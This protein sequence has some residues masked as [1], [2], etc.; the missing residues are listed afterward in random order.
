[1]VLRSVNNDLIGTPWLEDSDEI[2]SILIDEKSIRDV[3]CKDEID[4]IDHDDDFLYCPTNDQLPQVFSDIFGYK[5]VEATKEGE[6]KFKVKMPKGIIKYEYELIKFDIPVYK[7]QRKV[8]IRS[9]E[10]TEEIDI[11]PLIQHYDRRINVEDILSRVVVKIQEEWEKIHGDKKPSNVY[12]DKFEGEFKKEYKP[13][14]H[15]N[16]SSEYIR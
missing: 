8:S 16:S 14:E 4:V 10:G 1:M 2:D 9:K 15:P 13:E 7:F 5:K 12:Q 6:V 11:L 3:I